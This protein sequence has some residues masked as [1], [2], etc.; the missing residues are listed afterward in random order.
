MDIKIPSGPGA[1]APIDAVEDAAESAT[2]AEKVAE[3]TETATGLETDPISQIAEQVLE[4]VAPGAKALAVGDA[5]VFPRHANI[6]INRGKATA[7][8]VLTL[9][10]EMKKRVLDRF[11]ITL[12]EEVRFV[13][14]R[15]EGL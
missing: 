5:A 11:G 13:G 14:Q 3:T 7:K 4:E 6:I 9:A 10:A 1:G 8:E 15:P 2:G 12:E